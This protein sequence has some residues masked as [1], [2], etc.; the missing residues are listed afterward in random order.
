MFR[1]TIITQVY[2]PD[3]A[4]VGQHIADVA[5]EMVRRGFAVTVF[6]SARGYDDP[7]QRYAK[8]EV[9]GGVE[10]RRFPL[11]SFGKRSLAVRLA[12]QGLF[13]LQAMAAVCMGRRPDVILASTSPPFAGFGAGIVAWLRRAPLVWWVMDLN[14][15]QLIATGR[16]RSTALMARVFDAM[17]RF[18]IGAAKA[19]IAL[20]RFMATRLDG[21]RGC[22]AKM[23]V[24]PPWAPD[25]HSLSS[26]GTPAFR[27]R[28]GF[29][30]KFVVM[31]SGNHAVVH[32]LE[33]LLEAAE[34]LA[35]DPR[36][37]FAFIGGGAGKAAVE[38]RIRSGARNVVSLPYQPLET[39]GDSL[40]A[41]DLHVVSMGEA[42]VGIVHPCKIYGAIAIGKPILLLGPRN[43]AAGDIVADGELGWIVPHGDVPGAVQAIHAAAALAPDEQSRMSNRIQ[44]IAGGEYGYG[45]ALAKVAA[46]VEDAANE[47]WR[48]SL[49]KR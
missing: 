5:E 40:H 49:G 39:L 7:S 41:A 36:F 35:N 47:R 1:L 15:D 27:A 20:D 9:R 29:E 11:S 28:H 48:E 23:A 18:T 37:V 22:A 43:S 38:K 32:P 44:V 33:T 46:V 26:E 25:D 45:N 8:R 16:I 14:P 17:N 31:H 10:V 21:K 30:G 2:P 42:M 13:M 3:P 34:Q 6:T 19:V 4:A 24:I 12:A